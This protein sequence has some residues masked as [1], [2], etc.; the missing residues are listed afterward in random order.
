[1][2]GPPFSFVILV[3][4]H[5][6]C[7]QMSTNWLFSAELVLHSPSVPGGETQQAPHCH[8]G[9]EPEVSVSPSRST[10]LCLLATEDLQGPV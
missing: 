7:L 4:S 2:S 3:A 6:R 8:L 10:N 5:L 9:W 1:M